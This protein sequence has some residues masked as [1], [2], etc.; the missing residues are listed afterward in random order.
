MYIICSVFRYNYGKSEHVDEM[1]KT[2]NVC[3]IVEAK[4]SF[5]TLFQE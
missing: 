5:F 3:V 4:K 1:Q 2:T